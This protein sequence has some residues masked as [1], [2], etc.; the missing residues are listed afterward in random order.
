MG[1]LPSIISDKKGL[2]IE[3]ALIS[4]IMLKK[5]IFYLNKW[6]IFAIILLHP[7]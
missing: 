3:C 4:V 7:R 2:I 5:L 1:Y 6:P